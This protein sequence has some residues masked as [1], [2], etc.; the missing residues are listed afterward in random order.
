MA[1]VAHP[2]IRSL[3]LDDDVD[4]Y[5]I[6]D[7]DDTIQ[8]FAGGA[9]IAE[10]DAAEITFNSASAATDFKVLTDGSVAAISVDAGVNA[11]KGSVTLGY[12]ANPDGNNRAW[13]KVYPPA[14]T[15]AAG[16]STSLVSIQPDYVLTMN[17]T[18]PVAATLQ[19]EE[20]N[21][22]GSPTTAATLYIKDAPTEGGTNN[23]A[24]YVAAGDVILGGDIDLGDDQQIRFGDADDALLDF[25]GSRLLLQVPNEQPFAIE[26]T[27]EGSKARFSQQTKNTQGVS[28]SAVEIM[29]FE[30]PGS[31]GMLCMVVG[32]LNTGADTAFLDLLLCPEE[33]SGTPVVIASTNTR[34][35]PAARTY[36]IGLERQLKLLVAANTYDVSVHCIS[37]APSPL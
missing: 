14:L 37:G 35:T 1:I 36:S 25:D 4:T 21:L 34:G 17:G 30:A 6:S 13:L 20:P 33:A 23:A 15:T 7:T 3:L 10:F 19:L 5:I 31:D 22:S 28:T 29:D 18:V 32:H 12:T 9:E 8:F 11:G 24:I 27:T 2:R 26:N 16:K